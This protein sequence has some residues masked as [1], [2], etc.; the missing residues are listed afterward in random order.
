MQFENT[1]KGSKLAAE[2]VIVE[3]ENKWLKKYIIRNDISLIFIAWAPWAWKT[4][5]IQS[6]LD[7]DSFI[8]IDIDEYRKLFV[9]YNWKNASLYQDCSSRVATKIFDYCMK[10][11]LKVIF[12]G[13]LTSQIWLKNIQKWYR[14]KRKMWIVLIYQDPHISY[15]FTKVR[16]SINIRNVDVDT[17]LRIY[18]DSISYCFKVINEYKNIQMVVASKNKQ[19]EWKQN[20]FYSKDKF[21][22]F[23]S[24]EYNSLQ[25][26]EELINLGNNNDIISNIV[27][28]WKK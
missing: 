15:A 14:K 10:K 28:L 22:K 25:L 11:E 6:V 9:G 27:R 13:T 21:D 3:L 20:I 12:D 19:R 26:K 23:Y 24:V 5:F 2:Y 8:V 7:Y 1:K 4:E 16:Q 18:Y 17:F